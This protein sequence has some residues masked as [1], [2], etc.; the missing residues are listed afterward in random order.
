MAHPLARSFA[1]LGTTLFLV[2]FGFVLYSFYAEDRAEK[3]ALEF[4]ATVST[5]SSIQ[6]LLERAIAVGADGRQTRWIRRSGD[7]DWL[8]VT[9]TGATPLS[10]HICSIS[11]NS[12]VIDA[13]YVF[14][15]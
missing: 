11:A 6:G 9:F 1:Q 14:L 8:P 12:T 4:C 2:L 3:K 5:G 7:S 13:K 15:D 10:R